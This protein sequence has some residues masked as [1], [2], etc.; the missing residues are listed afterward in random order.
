V[1]SSILARAFPSLRHVPE[2]AGRIHHV[3]DAQSPGL[4]RRRARRGNA[5]RGHQVERFDVRPPCIEVVDHQLQHATARPAFIEA[6][7]QDETARAGV[8]NRDVA[9]ED[10]VESQRFVETFGAFEVPAGKERTNR[11]GA[12]GHAIHGVT[13]EASR[14]NVA[15]SMLVPHTTSATRLPSSRSRNGPNRA[16]VAAAPAGSTASFMSVNSS[17]IAR[18][19]ATSGMVT[20]PS[21]NCRATPKL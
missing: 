8:E 18:C 11:F 3:R 1:R 20:I 2:D 14:A 13:S 10:L 4:H 15:R 5:E 16:A 21:T 9:V 7:L 12:G 19:I 6:P 17:A